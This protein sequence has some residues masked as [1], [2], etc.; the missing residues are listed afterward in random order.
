MRRQGR[1]WT[2]QTLL[3]M[4]LVLVALTAAVMSSCSGSDG[5]SNGALCEQ[6]GVTDGPCQQN[7]TVVPGP[8]APPPCDRPDAPNPCPV[9][10]ICRRKA[11]SSQQR[12]YPKDPA[13]DDVNYDFRCDGSR[14]GET[15]RPQPTVTVTPS[16]Q[17]TAVAECGNGVQE[18]DEEC[19]GTDLN[20][21]ECSDFCDPPGG[22]L[23]C[24]VNGAPN[25]CEFNTEGCNG[26][27]NQ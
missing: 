11:D 18:G 2:R 13:S 25:E 14:P 19:D 10:L 27:C 21:A 20:N 9:E 26:L 15:P 16:P 5:D 3:L 6:C 23:A 22:T 17:P 7:F 1:L 4:P 24:R 8:D 12:C